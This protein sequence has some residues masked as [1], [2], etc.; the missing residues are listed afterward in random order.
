MPSLYVAIVPIIRADRDKV[1]SEVYVQYIQKS[2]KDK[3]SVILK[4]FPNVSEGI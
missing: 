4:Y 2:L 3:D 1:T